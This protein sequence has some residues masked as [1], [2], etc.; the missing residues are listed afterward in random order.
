[1]FTGIVESVGLIATLESHGNDARLTIDVSDL[2]LG[3]MAIGDSLSVSG[4]CL[5]LVSKDSNSVVVD[6]SAETLRCTT[7]GSLHRGSPVNLE[8]AMQVGDRFG[9]HIVSGH[10]DGVSTV[11]SR[12]PAG[13]SLILRIQ[14]P[15]ELGRYLAI[16]GSVCVD[17]VSLTVNTVEGAEFSVNLIP[18]TQAVTTLDQLQRGSSVN[19]EVDMIARYL[20]RLLADRQSD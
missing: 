20:E 8:R 11:V 4:V 3:D 2:D 15:R 1:M 14:A 5:S 12:E 18:H 16:K 13:E 17:G 9:G 7:L 6:V 10:V 19:I